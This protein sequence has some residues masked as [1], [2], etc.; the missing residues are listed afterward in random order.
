[1]TNRLHS[2]SVFLFGLTAV[3]MKAKCHASTQHLMLGWICF[4]VFGAFR[5]HVV[6]TCSLGFSEQRKS[7]QISEV[8]HDAQ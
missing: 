5:H 2:L 1:M 6:I 4:L 8:Q 7:L 3:V